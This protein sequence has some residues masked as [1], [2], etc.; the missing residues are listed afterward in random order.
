VDVRQR[1]TEI[2]HRSAMQFDLRQFPDPS[3]PPIDEP[4]AG[5][6]N[7]PVREPNPIENPDVPVR[8]PDPAEPNQI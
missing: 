2:Q 7:I 1:Q 6:D 5:P 3:S 4:P 8:E